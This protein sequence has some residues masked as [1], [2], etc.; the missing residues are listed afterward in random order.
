M[1]NMTCWRACQHQKL[2][3]I[4]QRIKMLNL[5]ILSLMMYFA[6]VTAFRLCWLYLRWLCRHLLTACIAKA[7]LASAVSKAVDPSRGQSNHAGNLSVVFREGLDVCWLAFMDITRRTVATIS[8]FLQTFLQPVAFQCSE[9]LDPRCAPHK[10]GEP[11][12]S[13]SP[14]TWHQA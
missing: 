12:K 10:R 13:S 3:D 7:D 14:W 11:C 2:L 4:E 1:L 9:G 6:F 5:Q 8:P